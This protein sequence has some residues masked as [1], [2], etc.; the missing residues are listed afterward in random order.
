MYLLNKT[1]NGLA[2][3]AALIAT[4][5]FAADLPVKAPPITP[6]LAPLWA[7]FYAGAQIGAAWTRDRLTETTS[8]VPPVTGSATENATSFIGGGHAGYNWQMGD[9]V[10]GPEADIEGT[11]LKTTDTCLIQDAGAGNATPGACFPGVQ[12]FSTQIFWQA[13]VRGRVGYAWKNA[14]IYAT[15]GVAFADIKTTYTQTVGAVVSS[16]SFRRIKAGYTVGGGLEYAF[17]AH[18]IARVEYRYSDFGTVSD[19]TGAAAGRFWTGYTNDHAITEH[20]VRVGVSYLFGE[21]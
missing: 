20:A 21:L 2:L 15:G 13:S 6:A 12:D 19:T 18:W 14:L 4:P 5:V 17:D 8:L 10:F 7:G 1:R 16:E 11:T 3:I 9:F